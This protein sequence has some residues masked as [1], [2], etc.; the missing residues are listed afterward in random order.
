MKNFLQFKNKDHVKRLAE[1]IRTIYPGGRLKI[2]E[3]CG[4][5]TM[6]IARYGL[7]AL[8][9]EGLRLISG[10][11]CPVCVTPQAVIDAAISLSEIKDNAIVTFGDMMSVPGT[12]KSLELRRAEGADIR[13][14]YSVY[15]MLEMAE[16]EEKNFIFI[17][18]GFETTTPG[19]ALS[20]LETKKRGLKN[21]YFLV[22]N[23]L[24]IPAMDALMR[25]DEV[26]IDGFLCPG[27]V[28]VII[29]SG[30]YR[31][32]ADGYSVPCVVAGFEPVDI[33]L[34]IHEIVDR[35]SK[36]IAGVGNAYNRAVT[37]KGNTQAMSILNR[38]FQPAMAEWRG[39]GVIPESG[40]SLRDEY[41]YLDALKRF[42]IELVSIP[43]PTGCR[44]GDILKGLI[45]P[46]E[47]SLF[48]NRCSPQAPVGPCMVSSE[49]SCAAYYKYGGGNE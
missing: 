17:S 4:T 9:P 48:G 16:E 18:I 1:K 24:V 45:I 21:V 46:P 35:I 23:R 13:I 34:A 6:A 2:M 7:R 26:Q 33:L 19:I 43:E 49:G 42:Q 27:H 32:I 5:H 41:S 38:V 37:E 25:S 15:D 22:A 28:S 31:V 29:G 10:P 3:V 36:N 44:C 40:L 39:I 12:E 30:A 20:I 8:M 47:C 14:L 11:G